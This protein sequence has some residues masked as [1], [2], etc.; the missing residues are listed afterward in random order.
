MATSV[1]DALVITLGMDAGDYQKKRKEVSAGLKNTREDADRTAK[2]L[3]A[4]GKR[5]A[6]FFSSIKNEMLALAGVSLSVAGVSAFVRN[7]TGGLQQLA[8]QSQALGMSARQLDGWSKAAQAA[9]SSAEK[10]TGTLGNFQNAIQ[11]YRNGDASSPIFRA[12]AMLNGDTGVTF[13]PMKQDSDSLMRTA[14]QAIQQERSGDRARYIATTMLGLDDAT[15]QAM[16]SGRFTQDVDK[17]G[18]QSGISDA[19]VKNAQRFNREWTDLQQ[20]LERTGYTIYGSLSPYIQQFTDYLSRLADWL[21]T[22]PR[23]TEA[24]VKSFFGTISEAVRVCDDAA[25]AVGGWKNA[26]LILVGASVLGKAISLTRGLSLAL[27]PLGLIGA[28]LALE[29]VVKKFEDKNPV[30]KNNPVADF[31]NH[32]PGMEAADRW[33]KKLHDWVKDTTGITLPRGDGYGQ[34]G[35]S[36]R[37][38]EALKGGQDEGRR[39][40]RRASDESKGQRNRTN[41]LLSGLFSALFPQAQA[42][43]LAPNLTGPAAGAVAK[44]PEASGSGKKLLDSLSDT[45]SDAEK[46]N[47]LPPGLLRSMATVES[48][49]NP[50]AVSPA[51]AQGLFQFMPGTARDMGLRGNDVFDPQKSA[52][53]AGRY[54]KELLKQTGSDLPAAV[55]A[56]NWGIGNVQRKGL[57]RA[58]AETR[59][60]VPK[61]L[62]G[63]QPGAGM[64]VDRAPAP[65]PVAQSAPQYHIGSVTVQSAA[66]RVDQ[67][68]ADIG[69]SAQNRT[70]VLGFD[71]RKTS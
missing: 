6:G 28:L 1:I 51:G 35:K 31:L 33:G 14:A 50:D 56:Y 69:R 55:A 17:Y 16:R 3:E 61:V 20:K 32:P 10:I 4:Q 48:G 41:E 12:L 15:F 67:L 58:P 22:H 71:T 13:D 11:A 19:D 44:P 21:S 68:T 5:A 63:I 23:E 53:A 64:T 57:A 45:F 39:E 60:Y 7:T 66:S 54:M 59:Q 9:G 38:L 30:L 8:V 25:Q 34:E 47:G 43:T 42:D 18:R 37:A 65:Q 24:A 52:E 70:R 26:L 40:A 62:S 27:G 36:P 49:G 29:T 46:R 2:E